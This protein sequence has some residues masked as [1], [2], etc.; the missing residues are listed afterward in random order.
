MDR[1]LPKGLRYLCLIL[2]FGSLSACAHIGEKPAN[3]FAFVG[4]PT[5]IEMWRPS[6]AEV[7]KDYR[8]KNPQM[9]PDTVIVTNS[10]GKIRAE[11]DVV[12]STKPM[13]DSF[14]LTSSIGE[15]CKQPFQFQ[16]EHFVEMLGDHVVF[17]EVVEK[18]GTGGF[19]VEMFED[20]LQ[21]YNRRSDLNLLQLQDSGEGGKAMVAVKLLPN[22]DNPLSQRERQ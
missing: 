22:P 21:Y 19:V 8:S 7:Q 18:D 15:W 6:F 2:T 4:K 12:V 16:K 5:K 11:F 17:S 3:S 1:S 13:A 14:S 10:C 9:P 20:Q